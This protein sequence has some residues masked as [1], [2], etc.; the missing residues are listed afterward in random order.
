MHGILSQ[1]FGSPVFYG[2]LAAGE[3]KGRR[4]HPVVKA[5]LQKYYHESNL[6]C[7]MQVESAALLVGAADWDWPKSGRCPR[8]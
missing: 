2:A 8:C 5:K 7:G 3:R 1:T 6:R 4:I